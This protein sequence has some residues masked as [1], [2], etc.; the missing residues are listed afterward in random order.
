MQINNI[1]LYK[2]RDHAPRILNF[3]T[4]QVN[5]VT[6]DSKSG[7]S[8]IL[9]IVDYCLGSRSCKIPAG[10]I[11][12]NVTW[13]GICVT[14]NNTDT[15]FIGRLNPDVKKVS[16]TSEACL[17]KLEDSGIIPDYD[18]I[19]D[20]VSTDYLIRFLSN[21][22]GISKDIDCVP[23]TTTEKAP[24]N[25][26]HARL[27]CYQPQTLIDQQ[28][29]LFY[30]QTEQM[31]P[32]AIQATLPYFLGAIREDQVAIEAEIKKLKKELAKAKQRKQ[33][34]EDL[35]NQGNEIVDSLLEEAK[36]MRL[37]KLPNTLSL[38]TKEKLD[39][40]HS[41]KGWE[42]N[43]PEATHSG[44]GTRLNEL[45]TSRNDYLDELGRIQDL[46]AKTKSYANNSKQFETELTYQKNRLDSI[47]LFDDNGVD[48]Q[49]C[50]ICGSKLDTEV[51][52]VSQM[53]ETLYQLNSNL[54][55]ATYDST[56]AE[57]YLAKLIQQE[58]D[59]KSK[60]ASLEASINAIYKIE[61]SERK[62]RDLNLERGK[63]IGKATLFL[64]SIEA[65]RNFG[66]LDNQISD[67]QQKLERFQA[68]V[69]KEQTLSRLEDSIFVIDKY[70]NNWL[71]LL[72]IE[73]IG[74][75]I[76]FDLKKLGIKTFLDTDKVL[77]LSEIGSGANWVSYHLLIIFAL[78]KYFILNNR[79]VPR[80]IFIDQPSQAYFPPEHSEG[81]LTDTD[82]ESVLKMFN[83]IFDRTEE[84]KNQL[85]VIIMEH[86]S[87]EDERYQN[88]IIEEWRN[89]QKLIPEEWINE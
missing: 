59:I 47:G 43:S 72:D 64:D 78:H 41:I 34:I 69:D 22:L 17:L 28:E 39:I 89:G 15:Y 52:S 1:I 88:Y 54:E 42:L 71:K 2:D 27:Y 45:I 85:Q 50:P 67:I 86:A 73:H 7:K 29:Y 49:K 10:I 18:Q 9:N 62:R 83:F 16:T 38:S 44:T 6:G 63:V 14:Y 26:R 61:S 11:R 3:N 75:T 13:F 25:F 60:L 58:L 35:V 77:D 53:L 21:Q 70:M 36:E 12:E 30:Q 5:I 87:L 82:S 57:E 19:T 37:I 4:G 76:R 65:S 40:L 84:L 46:I 81:D 24:V 51:P 66:N 68:L 31:I 55:K 23:T 74:A 33:E 20:N 56:Q 32:Q 80:F 48:S 8:A 79:P